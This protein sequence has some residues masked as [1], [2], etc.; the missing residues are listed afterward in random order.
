[1]EGVGI[2]SDQFLSPLNIKKLNIV[3]PENPKFANLRDYWEDETMRKITD[4]LH[5]F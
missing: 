1:M 2:S 5:E 4:L 3:S